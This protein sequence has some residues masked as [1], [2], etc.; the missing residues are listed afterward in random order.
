MEIE[1]KPLNFKA[2]KMDYDS[3]TKAVTPDKS[4]GLLKLE[5]RDSE[6]HLSWVNLDTHKE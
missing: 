3:K 2:G 6:T 5:E 1:K 4:H